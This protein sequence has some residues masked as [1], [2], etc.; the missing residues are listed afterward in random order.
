MKKTGALTATAL[1][2]AK[3]VFKDTYAANTHKAYAQ[4]LKRFTSYLGDRE[5]DD[6]IVAAFLKEEAERGLAPASLSL[7]HAAI[8]A[9]A[10][11]AD[12][13][14]PRGPLTARTLRAL[15]RQHAERGRGQVDGLRRKDVDAAARLAAAEGTLLGLRDAALLRLGSDALL[16]ISELAAVEVEHLE[17]GEDGSGSL[18]L[19][20]SK[21][22]QEGEGKTLYVCRTTMAAI[23]AW[24][25]ASGVSSGPLFRAISRDGTRARATAL[26]ESTVPRVIRRRARAAGIEGRMSGH[27][28][29]VGSA[30]S[31]VARG[32]STAELMQAG[33]W[34][35]ERTA[36]RYAANELAANG[37]VARYFEDSDE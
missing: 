34:T 21:T 30:Q 25:E 22:D 31:L 7:I 4:A 23:G 1:R 5:A 36:T 33:R 17:A 15:K 24:R 32:A 26:S 37:A 14:D 28:L 27:S 8:G 18:R 16:R 35:D 13:D 3:N 11:F 9:A 6:E 10:R 20:R 12:A 19:P 2:L 29:R